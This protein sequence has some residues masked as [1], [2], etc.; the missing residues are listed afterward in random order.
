MPKWF[1]GYFVDAHSTK[2]AVDLTKAYRDGTQWAVE[3]A[4][5][6]YIK[7]VG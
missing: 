3:A 5:D 7:I 2:D 1:K 4:L 6:G